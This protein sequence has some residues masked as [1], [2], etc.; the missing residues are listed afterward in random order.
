[1][2]LIPFRPCNNATRGSIEASYIRFANIKGT[3][4]M[5]GAFFEPVLCRSICVYCLFLQTLSMHLL[6]TFERFLFFF[7][8]SRGVSLTFCIIVFFLNTFFCISFCIFLL[9]RV[10]IMWCFTPDTIE[11][12]RRSNCSFSTQKN[13]YYSTLVRPDVSCLEGPT[14]NPI[15]CKTLS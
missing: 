6:F 3:C 2:N 15:Y 10:I 1:M 4:I 14:L 8:S 13:Y 12:K 9:F 5:H 11:W 7:F